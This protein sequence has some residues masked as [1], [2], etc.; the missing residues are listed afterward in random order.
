MGAPRATDSL[1]NE[2]P[3]APSLHGGA[4]QVG[5][6]E[7]ANQWPLVDAGAVH[8]CIY[9][10]AASVQVAADGLAVRADAELGLRSSQRRFRQRLDFLHATPLGISHQ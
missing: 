4:P 8:Q 1:L 7:G 3:R 5:D 2:M 9:F 6:R 10:N